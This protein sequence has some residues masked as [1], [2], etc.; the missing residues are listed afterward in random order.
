VRIDPVQ[1]EQVLVNLAVNARDAMPRGG[2]LSIQ[3]EPRSVDDQR[4]TRLGVSPGIYCCLTVRD[5]G[6]GMPD[7]VAARIFE[8]FFTTKPKGAGTG[9]GLSTV[10]G[11]VHQAGGAIWVDSTLGQGS[12]FTL[13]LP[14]SSSE[15]ALPRATAARVQLEHGTET[16]LLVE[17]GDEVRAITQAQLEHAGYRVLSAGN[18]HDALHLAEHHVGPIHLALTDVMMPLMN[19]AD[20]ADKLVRQRPGLPVIF[21]SGYTERHMLRR[22]S[23]GQERVSL[24]KPF[25]LTELL[26]CVRE[27]L[28]TRLEA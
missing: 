12:C 14:T 13:L 25:S 27:H 20:L 15:P 16:I 24:H 6:I 26:L 17:D 7:F 19:G 23:L 3:V 9:L 8:P 21:M 4:A 28:D 1:L 11:I 10:F 18:G 5:T 2:T 22:T